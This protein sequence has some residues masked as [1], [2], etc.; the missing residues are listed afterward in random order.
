MHK[1]KIYF[2]LTAPTEYM[3]STRAT[4]KHEWLLCR[5]A[6]LFSLV[7]PSGLGPTKMSLI[8]GREQFAIIS[9]HDCGPVFGQGYDL[10]VLREKTGVLLGGS[11]LG[12]TYQCPPEQQ[13][14]FFTGRSDFNITDVEV[15]GIHR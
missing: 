11:T 10:C 1:S 12:R 9:Y 13:K 7:N 6:F 3:L 2:L 14:E 15:F 8:N 5:Q 4:P